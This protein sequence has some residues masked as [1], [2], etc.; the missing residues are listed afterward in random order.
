MALHLSQQQFTY[1]C[2]RY[3]NREFGYV[4]FDS[5]RELLSFVLKSYKGNFQAL[6]LQILELYDHNKDISN[7]ALEDGSVQ[8][9]RVEKKWVYIYQ[10]NGFDIYEV[11]KETY[12]SFK[13]HAEKYFKEDL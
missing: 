8:L 5:I 10:K 12:L 3:A 2:K 1:L 13:Q 9:L 7:L 4:Y 6:E 11:L